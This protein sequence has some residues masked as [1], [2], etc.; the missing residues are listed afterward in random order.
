[1]RAVKWQREWTPAQVKT[2][3]RSLL[4]AM[5]DLWTRTRDQAM[6]EKPAEASTE[7]WPG[8]VQILLAC[9]VVLDQAPL[10]PAEAA[11]CNVAAKFE[12]A[13]ET[14]ATALATSLP[15]GIPELGF[16]IRSERQQMAQRRRHRRTARRRRRRQQAQAGE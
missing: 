15:G 8:Y 2:Q 12:M 1:M 7:F 3:L 9:S 11:N 16:Y 6:Q 5:A 10:H 14:L 4:A 13:L